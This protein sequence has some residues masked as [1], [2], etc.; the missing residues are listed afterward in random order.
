MRTSGLNLD[1]II[2]VNGGINSG[3]CL[4]SYDAL[5]QDPEGYSDFEDENRLSRSV[6]FATGFVYEVIPEPCRSSV[7]IP[8]PGSV[9]RAWKLEHG[10]RD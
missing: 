3:T 2:L 9:V 10:I 8:M 1:R 5:P 6:F 4:F 7:R